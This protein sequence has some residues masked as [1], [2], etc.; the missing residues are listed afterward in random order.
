MTRAIARTSSACGPSA[1]PGARSAQD[2]RMV[3]RLDPAIA[4]VWRDPF[5][6]QFGIDPVRTVLREVSSAEER[7]IAALTVGVSRSGLSM[8][9]AA[10]GA[11]E[12]D[13]ARLLGRLGPLLRG[14]ALV[15][16][17]RRVA[18]VGRGP[19]VGQV[20]RKS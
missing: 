19:P 14:P 18:I 13:A 16:P 12:T 11:D 6:L 8:I 2:M 10:A 9:A 15:A 5:S 17:E 20:D 3:L 1:T 7:M 4:M